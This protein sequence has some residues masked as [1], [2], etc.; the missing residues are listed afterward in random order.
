MRTVLIYKTNQQASRGESVG[1]A[2]GALQDARVPHADH[3]TGH[4]DHGSSEA[5]DRRLAIPPTSAS[6]RCRRDNA[7]L[8]AGSR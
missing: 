4:R 2:T 6:D 7:R 1:I 3:R 8:R 5:A